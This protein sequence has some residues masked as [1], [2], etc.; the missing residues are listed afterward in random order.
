MKKYVFTVILLSTILAVSLGLTYGYVKLQ[1][2]PEEKEDLVVVTSFYP[3]Y[4]A[5]LNIVGD[6]EGITLEN[7]SEPQTGC[8][9]DF[10]L[11]P[12]DMKLLSTAD[13]FVVN[14]GGIESFMTEVASVYPDLLII[15]ACENITLLTDSDID[16]EEVVN[17]HAWMSI[18]DYRIMV[19]TIAEKLEEK[20]PGHAASFEQNC[21]TYDDKLSKLEQQEE[22]LAANSAGTEVILFH[23]AYAYLAKDLGL[24]VRMTMDLDEERQV[25]AGEVADVVSAADSG[26]GIILAEELY[27]ADMA[28]TVSAETQVQVVFIDPLT[29]GDYEADSYLVHMQENLDLLEEALKER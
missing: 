26:A 8:L 24:S 29:R 13:V 21:K 25:S 27:G 18:P 23:E 12:E 5:A 16:G 3:M 2:S 20:D 9:H 1:T 7:L 11:T 17:A 19:Q 15:E 6:T 14:G 28:R 10:Q 22:V 4:I